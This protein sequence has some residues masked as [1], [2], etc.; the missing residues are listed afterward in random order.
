MAIVR[1]ADEVVDF[2]TERK[3]VQV[4]VSYEVVKLFSEQLYAS[5]VKAIEE[6]VVN[7]WDA[8]ASHCSVHVDIDS[9]RPLIAVFDDGAG[10]TLQQ[11]ESLW[12]IGV[13]NKPKI[14]A[15]RKQ[16]GKFGI[17]K[18]ASYAVARRATYISRTL[19][20]INVVSI[21]FQA[22]AEATDSAGV[23]KPVKLKLRQIADLKT[24]EAS[25]AFQAASEVLETKPKKQELETIPT[26]TMV[27]L[28][29]LK[30]KSQ[31]LKT[32]RLRWV[33]QTA[34]PLESDFSLYLNGAAIKSSKTLLAKVAAFDVR[35]LEPARLSDLCAVTGETWV[36]TEKGLKSPSFPS[37]IAGE[38][39]ATR[40]VTLRSRWKERRSGAQSWFLRQSAQ[41]GLSDGD[42]SLIS[43][44]RPLIVLDLVS[45]CS[46]CRS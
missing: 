8:G 39:F 33:L 17:G 27:V 29:D 16:I 32:G 5:P 37:G 1:L 30:E 24:L 40:E 14:S 26:W 46:D 34:M 35:D 15:P 42:R 31:Q 44:L 20:G 22:F 9:E 28:E 41:P 45:L 25:K 13:S 36:K 43:A 4:Q 3:E 7:S 2:S 12:H 6:L 10:M 18:L 21:D 23:A 19:E 11:L 38:A